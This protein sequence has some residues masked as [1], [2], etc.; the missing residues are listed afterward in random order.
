MICLIYKVVN[1]SLDSFLC[2]SE[3]CINRIFITWTNLS[4]QEMES[5]KLMLW[6]KL[7]KKLTVGIMLK[8]MLTTTPLKA[9]ATL[10]L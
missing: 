7:W 3:V 10:L 4:I 1:V 2:S 5:S 6:R 8:E 9:L